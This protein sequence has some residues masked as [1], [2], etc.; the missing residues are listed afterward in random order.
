M[1][2][3]ETDFSAIETAIR[4]AQNVEFI[5]HRAHTIFKDVDAPSR[6]TNYPKL[7]SNEA[8]MI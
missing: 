6:W 5:A 7:G 1:L 2:T 3:F 4:S 8:Q